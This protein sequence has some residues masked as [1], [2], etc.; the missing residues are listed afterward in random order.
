[1]TSVEVRSKLVDALRIDLVGPSEGVGDQ[2]EALPQAPSSWYLAG[3]LVP[4]EAVQTQGVDESSSEEVDEA[5]DGKGLDD[6]VTPEPAAARQRYLPSSIGLSVLVPS[7]TGHLAVKVSWGDYRRRPEGPET[8]QRT[9][10]SEAVTID[11]TKA[12]AQSKPINVPGSQGL[13]VAYLA[14]KVGSLDGDAGLPSDAHIVSVFLVNR[15]TPA[16]DERK[17]EAFAFQVEIELTTETGFL[18]RPNLRSLASSDWDERVADLQYRDAGEYAVG[19]NIATQAFLEGGLCRRVRTRWNPQAEVEHVAW[20]EIPGAEMSMDALSRLADFSEASAKLSPIVAEYR[21]W[22]DA[23]TGEVPNKPKKRQETSQELLQRA[24]I[25]ADRIQRGIELL[26]DPA[27]LEAF[28]LANKVMAE[29]ARRRLGVMQ[30]K[31]PQTVQPVWRP[32]QLAFLLMN[33][34][35]IAQPESKDR[36]V[37]DL[38]F[39]P[40]GGGKT[41]A[42]LGLA[43][44]TLILRRL[45]NPGINSAGVS[46]LMRYTLRLLTLDQLSRA[47]TLLCALELE[48]KQD[49]A[50]LG[51]WPFEIGLWVGRAATPNR[52][53]AKGDHDPETARLRTLR[54]MND[55]RKASPIPLEECPWCGTKFKGIS[56]RLIP[57]SDQPED[58]RISCVNRECPF[59][60]G[61]N[62]PIVAVDEPLYRRLPCF[63]IATVDKFAA[64]PWTGPVGALF[65]RVQRYD[66]SG[67]Y[68]PCDSPRGTKLPQ[69]RLLPPDLIV[70]D[71]LHLIS[72]PLGTMVG[73]YETALDELCVSDR[74]GQPIRP[75]IVAS[76]ATVRRAETQIRALFNRRLTD[77]FPPPGP[78]RRDSF[79]ARI[80]PTTE[81][82]ARLYVG[83]AAQGRSP[84]VAMLR[85]YLALLGAGQKWYFQL[86]QAGAQPNPVD[87]YMTLV[88]Y[89]NSLRELGGARRVI[90]DEVRNRLT[91]YSARKRVGETEGLFADREIDYEPVEL[92]SRVSTAEVAEARHRLGVSY[93]DKQSVDV[94]IATNMISVGID[95]TRLGLMVVFGQP[96]TSAEYIQATSRVGRD[97]ALPGLIV[98][99]Y[100]V[101]K[102]RDRSHYE[103]FAAY[104]ESFYRSVEATSVT[105]FSPRALDKGL[106]AT[107]VGLIRQQHQPMTPP[108]G[109][110]EILNE[111]ARLEFAIRALA[112]RAYSFSDLPPEEAERIRQR[113]RERVLDL[114]DDWAKVA[115]GYQQVGT[116]LQYNPVEAGGAKQLLYDFLSPDVRNLPSTNPR[117]KFRANRSLRDVEPNVNV[118]VRTLENAELE[119]EVVS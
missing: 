15:R 9:P 12:T 94:A 69:G 28:R 85:I 75:K 114:L 47:S 24:R 54:F 91:K 22:I 33:L 48:R 77:I 118:W 98:T 78:D 81:S 87:P 65:G 40:T 61:V 13:Q 3:F 10:R 58:L 109:A 63:I 26:A 105:P 108:L 72:G 103:R 5:S 84:K 25:S 49:V 30:G 4:A 46:V 93:E 34:T 104:H 99:I 20:K 107:L 21:S 95:I 59:S 29:S 18:P 106:A 50:K 82:N 16:P 52:M 23:Q 56:F 17:D 76:T 51:E 35:G 8:W 66:S 79:F 45:E 67:F 36:E 19:H 88:G 119:E 86:R 14:R 100:N 110:I 27:C 41:E 97:P 44:F 43:A 38:L 80:V 37:V 83:V 42:Y 111:R 39:F 113:V 6:D 73:L 90:E 31:N 55:D 115:Q 70:Q 57:N 2:N 60:R 1:M 32:F 74:N 92:T 68:G 64:L 71:E 117:M 89:F 96:K 62:L 53:G 102:P 116:G 112:E 7:K 101:H 11:L